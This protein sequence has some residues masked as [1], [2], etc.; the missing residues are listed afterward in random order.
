MSR[1]PLDDV[2]T[3]GYRGESAGSIQA[4]L[5]STVVVALYLVLAWTV[6]TL[7]L[8]SDSPIRFIVTVPLLLFLPGYAFLSTL[9]PGRQSPDEQDASPL[10]RS[11]RFGS[12]Q[13]I[14]QR[15]ISWGER[16]ALSFGLSLVWLPILA[17]ALAATPWSLSVEPM[18]A[19]LAVFVTLFTVV[20]AV[21]RARLP[22]GERFVL[23]YR[24]WIADARA[25]FGRSPADALLTAVLALSML[26][27]LASLGYTLAVPTDAT[28]TSEFYVGTI[29]ES[30]QLIYEDYPESFTAGQPTNLTVGIENQEGT[31]TD[32]VV[33]A[34]FQRVEVSGGQTRVLERQGARRFRPT[35]PANETR[36]TWARTHELTPP[37]S[38]ENGSGNVRLVYLLY[39]DGAPANPTIENADYRTWVWP[40]G[41]TPPSGTAGAN[42][43]ATTGATNATAGPN[44]S[45]GSSGSGESNASASRP[46]AD[47][48]NGGANGA[49][50]ASSFGFAPSF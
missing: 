38:T 45:S 46:T 18:F 9:F 3:G 4:V 48:T 11:A 2:R 1:D 37:F 33:I 22:R 27:A 50:S 6:I 24:R 39:L 15:G 36:D 26:A 34:Q 12:V 41:R 17:L 25:A 28:S 8:T 31:V 19:T 14:E 44:A 49:V 20:G 35:V 47:A 21:R 23:P 29:N 13:S 7:P 32:Y 16:S 30:G 5:G 10:S 43:T 42:A 40:D